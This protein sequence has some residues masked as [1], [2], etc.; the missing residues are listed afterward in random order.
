[1]LYQDSLQKNIN[2][3]KTMVEDALIEE[4][5]INPKEVKQY[6]QNST[7]LEM[8]EEDPIYV[9]HYDEVYWAQRIIQQNEKLFCEA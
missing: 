4:F 5:H 3:F 1:M 6:I 7:F 9:T 8:L 2:L